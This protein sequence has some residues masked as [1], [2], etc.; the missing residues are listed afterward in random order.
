MFKSK[1]GKKP[2]EQ[3]NAERDR[4]QHEELSDNYKGRVPHKLHRLQM[5]NRVEKNNRHDV[6]GNTLAED[7][8]EQFR[9]FSV[10]NDTYC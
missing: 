7:T 2:K 10:V 8:A 1:A 9:L 5:L 4:T 6:V 3:P